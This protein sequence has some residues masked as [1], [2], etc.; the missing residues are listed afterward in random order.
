MT[1]LIAWISRDQRRFAALHVASDSRISWGSAARRWDAGRKVFASRVTPDVWAYC[2]DVL[3]PG[4]VLSQLVSAGDEGLLFEED[5]GAEERHRLAVE[6]MKNSF[7]RRHHAPDHGFTILHASRDG[8]GADA[9]PRLWLTTF[10]EKSRSWTDQERYIEDGAVGT[11]VTLGSGAASV[12]REEHRWRASAIGGTSRAIFSAFCDALAKGED[13][14]SGGSPQLGSIYPKRAGAT[15][16]VL[17]EGELYLHGLPIRELTKPS[18]I[19]WYDPL[20]QR[21]DPTTRKLR[22]GAAR[23]P[24]PRLK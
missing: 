17:H 4:L 6:A 19:E 10:D 12:K 15:A 11:V 22:E 7:H 18:S 14:R 1:S 16:G 24:R 3:F 5:G 13:P 21:I 9:R 20:F 2:G 8:E 23:Q